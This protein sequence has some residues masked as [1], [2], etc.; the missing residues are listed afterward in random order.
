[1]A[2]VRCMYNKCNILLPIMI[3]M[4]TSARR[5]VQKLLFYIVYFYIWKHQHDDFAWTNGLL[6]NSNDSNF[7]THMS[8]RNR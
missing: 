1:M 6:L 8:K 5:P 7:Y 2:V 3:I 4:E